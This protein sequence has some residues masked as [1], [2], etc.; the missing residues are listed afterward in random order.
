ML[1]CRVHKARKMPTEH[2][3]R[4]VAKELTGKRKNRP[5]SSTSNATGAKSRSSSRRS[6]RPP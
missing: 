4:E 2:L 1:G 3:K 5:R 6:T